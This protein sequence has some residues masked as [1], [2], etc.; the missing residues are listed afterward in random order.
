[1]SL[2]TLGESRLEALLE[3]AQLLHS[4]LDLDGLLRHLLRSV[5]GRL[6]ASKGLIAVVKEGVMRI[7]LVRGLPKL[8]AGEAFDETK[9]RAQGID[10]ILPIGDE[11]NPIGLLAINHPLKKDIGEE[12]CEFLRAQLGIAASGIANARAHTEANELNKALDQ[13][14]QELRTLL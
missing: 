6:L 5:M 2:T 3:S 10:T 1:M 9:A 11:N 12:E 14:V 13:K 8:A 7:E 4:S